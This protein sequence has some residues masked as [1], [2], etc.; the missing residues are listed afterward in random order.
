MEYYI[1]L[2]ALFLGLLIISKVIFSEVEGRMATK[3]TNLLWARKFKKKFEYKRTSSLIFVCVLCYIITTNEA[4]L[5]M[6]WFLQLIGFVAV[7][8][9][10]DGL[11]Q[12]IGYYYIRLRFKKYINECSHLEEEIKTTLETDLNDEVEDVNL[13]YDAQTILNNYVNED[14]H[15]AIVS[16]DGGKFVSKLTNL[17]PIT[18]VVETKKEEAKERLNEDIKVTSYT[19]EGKLPFKDEKL[20][21]IMNARANYDKFEMY[22][23]LKPHSYAIIDQLGSDNYSEIISLF[24]PFRI[25]GSWDKDNCINT[26]KEI[27]FDIVDSYEDFG[28]LRF[29]SLGSVYNFINKLVPAGSGVNQEDTFINFYGRVLKAIKENEFFELSTHN[30]LVVAYKRDN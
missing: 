29:K 26:L 12:V 16:N 15:L 4:M 19:P 27:G 23:V 5:S 24:M 22:R 28:K 18:Y 11:S 6:I 21:V 25:K 20:D 10:G 30:F 3:N 9:I 13:N 7:G 14:T 2:V 17:P 1:Y 8:V